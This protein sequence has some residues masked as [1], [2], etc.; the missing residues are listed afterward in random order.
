MKKYVGDIFL[1]VDDIRNL[2]PTNL[3]SNIDLT[4]FKALN[5]IQQ[6]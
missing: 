4:N 5:E 2:S 6:V 3:V 1:L